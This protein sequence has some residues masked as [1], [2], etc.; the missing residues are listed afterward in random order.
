MMIGG[1]RPTMIGAHQSQD[2]PRIV[3]VSV[4]SA[5][6]SL[7]PPRRRRGVSSAGEGRRGTTDPDP[8]SDS[9]SVRGGERLRLFFPPR[10][11]RREGDVRIIIIIIIIIIPRARARVFEEYRR[12]R[13]P[14]VVVDDAALLCR[15]LV[16]A[17]REASFDRR[18]PL[19]ALGD[20]RD[21]RQGG[22]GAGP[23]AKAAAES[24]GGRREPTMMSSGGDGR[25]D[26]VVV[27]VL[28]GV[29]LFFSRRVLREV[30]EPREPPRLRPERVR[31]VGLAPRARGERSRDVAHRVAPSLRLRVEG[32]SRPVVGVVRGG[33]D[34]EHGARL[35]APLRDAPRDAPGLAESRRLAAHR[36]ARVLRG[37]ARARQGGGAAE[38]EEVRA[39]G[40]RGEGRDDARGDADR[41]EPTMTRDARRRGGR[42][43]RVRVRAAGGEVPRVRLRRRV[44]VGRGTEG[45]A[46]ER[47]GVERE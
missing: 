37:V 8:D 2:P 25:R 6:V 1:A 47:R 4:A 19:A 21:E 10:R 29:F 12:T 42:R 35:R 45:H 24:G 31:G 3:V 39:R 28:A 16:E 7:P 38:R 18:E 40:A 43:G 36:A 14:V 13:L 11:R 34:D 23:F 17:F 22:C 15:E 20:G 26:V 46:R 33:E 5:A 41:R 27:V 32:H 30:R 44:A 9:D